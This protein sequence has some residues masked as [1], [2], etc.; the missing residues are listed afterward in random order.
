MVLSATLAFRHEGRR[1]V[2]KE[3]VACLG[4]VREVGLNENQQEFFTMSLGHP[5]QEH[6]IDSDQDARA[7]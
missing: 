6:L 7:N 4:F 1:L 5:R 2:V 3:Q